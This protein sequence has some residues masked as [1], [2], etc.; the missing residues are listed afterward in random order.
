MQ[1][2]APNFATSDQ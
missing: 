2:T 1:D